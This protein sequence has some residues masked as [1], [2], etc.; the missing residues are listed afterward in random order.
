MNAAPRFLVAPLRKSRGPVCREILEALPSWFGIPES[1][2]DYVAYADE[3]TVLG[4]VSDGYAGGI[5]IVRVTSDAACEI[6]L[7]AVRPELH[8]RGLGRML[9][10]AAG[11][12]AKAHG[13]R[14]LTVKTIGPSRL[15]ASYENTRRFYLSVGFDPIE[16]FIGL[17]DGNPCLL[18]L[19]P[20]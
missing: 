18:L 14:Y 2:D 10:A 20:L 8:R 11:D 5:T 1:I 9:V 6:H 17:W 16:E 15:D 19:K 3:A 7:I 12:W 4:A 13:R